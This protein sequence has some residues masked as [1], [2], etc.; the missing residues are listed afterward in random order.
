MTPSKAIP[1][2]SNE[3]PEEAYVHNGMLR[4]AQYLKTRL[5]GE[6]ILTE[7]KNENL[8]RMKK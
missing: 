1:I 2:D 3:K 6:Y 8:L 7:G 4:V 5:L